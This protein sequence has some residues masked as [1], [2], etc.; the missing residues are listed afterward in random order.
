MSKVRKRKKK[1]QNV[2][3]LARKKNKLTSRADRI[4]MNAVFGIVDRDGFGEVHDGGFGGAV[5]G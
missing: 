5:C 2:F 4:A 3:D 1:V